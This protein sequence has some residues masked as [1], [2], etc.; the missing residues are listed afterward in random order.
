[1]SSYC[2]KC[3]RVHA[4]LVLKLAQKDTE[5]GRQD[6]NIEALHN[7]ISVLLGER[8]ELRKRVDELSTKVPEALWPNEQAKCT[9]KPEDVQG[10]N[11]V[12]RPRVIRTERQERDYALEKLMD[13]NHRCA[14]LEKRFREEHEG[15]DSALKQSNAWQRCAGLSAR[16]VWRRCCRRNV[17]AMKHSENS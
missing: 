12:D 7:R 10:I 13:A 6:E 14:E 11:I 15:R 2:E 5:I 16:E 9:L 8:A 3:A 1:M 4:E 17:S